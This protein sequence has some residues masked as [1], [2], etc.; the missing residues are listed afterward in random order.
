MK[1]KTTP[2]TQVR[3]PSTSTL[4]KTGASSVSSRSGI[5]LCFL[6]TAGM[7]RNMF[8]TNAH[9]LKEGTFLYHSLETGCIK[10]RANGWQQCQPQ[11]FCFNFKE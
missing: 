1:E 8:L 9:R 11:Q 3:K 7:W 5:V 10:Q 4:C 2:P 6:S